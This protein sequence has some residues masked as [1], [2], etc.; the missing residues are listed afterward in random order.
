MYSHFL[1]TLDGLSTIQAFGWEKA[2]KDL[3]VERLD[4]SQKPY[5]LMYCIQRWLAL[6]LDLFAGGM[7]IIVVSLALNLRGST[8]PGLLGVSLNSVLS[9]WITNTAEQ[10]VF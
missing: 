10:T 7:A 2:S 5:Y 9:K 4:A 1:E 3:N 6:V 8:S